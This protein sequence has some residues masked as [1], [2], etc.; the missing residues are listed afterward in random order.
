M[1]SEHVKIFGDAIDRT[2]GNFLYY[3]DTMVRVNDSFSHTKFHISSGKLL[4]YRT[5]APLVK[6]LQP[7][8]LRMAAQYKMLGYGDRNN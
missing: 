3:A 7:G 4:F 2:T 1:N 6:K 5:L 8:G